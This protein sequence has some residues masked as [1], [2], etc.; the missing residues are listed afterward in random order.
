MQVLTTL[1]EAVSLWCIAF[2]IVLLINP[3]A[4]LSEALIGAG[5]IGLIASYKITRDLKAER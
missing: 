1:L 3:D 2:A 5:V 4:G